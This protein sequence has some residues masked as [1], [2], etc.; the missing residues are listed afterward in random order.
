MLPYSLFTSGHDRLL[1]PEG[2]IDVHRLGS[3]F[4]LQRIILLSSWQSTGLF[5]WLRLTRP[6]TYN[7]WN[8]FDSSVGLPSFPFYQFDSFF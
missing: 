4:T 1:R 2:P 8:I 3:N 7:H 5:P 6:E